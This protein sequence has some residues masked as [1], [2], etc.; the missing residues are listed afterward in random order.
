MW[1]VVV[2]LA[3]LTEVPMYFVSTENTDN[4]QSLTASSEVPT[5]EV[6]NLQD[7]L[8]SFR[9]RTEGTT[10]FVE[11]E[12]DEEHLI[13]FW[14]LWYNNAQGQDYARLRLAATQGELVTNPVVDVVDFIRR[15]P[16][17]G[18]PWGGSYS[19][20][21]TTFVDFGDVLDQ[22]A[23]T[24]FAISIRFRTEVTGAD[25][26]LANKLD[27]LNGGWQFRITSGDVLTATIFDG[28]N[29]ETATT[30]ATPYLDGLWHEARMEVDHTLEVMRLYVDNML[31][32]TSADIS[33][34]GDLSSAVVLA[35]G[36]GVG[37]IADLFDGQLDEFR[38]WDGTLP[39]TIQST[40]GLIG[41]FSAPLPA[42]LGLYWKANTGSGTVAIDETTN[43]FD[44]T[45][46]NGF[47]IPALTL[48]DFGAAIGFAGTGDVDFGDILDQG[49]A[50][51]FTV[52]LR[53]KTTLSGIDNGL[54]G[55][56]DG[57]GWYG[58][59]NAADNFS[60]FFTDGVDTVP[61]VFSATPYL[62][63]AWHEVR[64]EW[65]RGADGVRLYADN[66]LLVGIVGLGA[67]G[68]LAN[69]SP[70]HV[71]TIDVVN[72]DWTGELD[73]FRFWSTIPT[74]AQS[75]AGF[76]GE[77]TIPLPT[78]LELYWKANE[79][80]G[81]IAYDET[82]N[83]FNGVIT[84]GTWITPYIFTDG[85]ESG[86]TSGWVG[87]YHQIGNIPNPQPAT[88]FRIDVNFATNPDGFVE[89]GALFLAPRLQFPNGQADNWQP[90]NRSSAA[91]KSLMA[92]GDETRGD[93]AN[94]RDVNFTIKGMTKDQHWGVFDPLHRE[95]RDVRPV[96]AVLDD[97]DGSAAL[98]PMN[99]TYYGYFQAV[100]STVRSNNKPARISLR[101]P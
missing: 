71:G 90:T 53:F 62:D 55:K 41:E 99:Y 94:K 48:A 98:Y 39:T 78:G 16:R 35:A 14:G 80:A 49:P 17:R 86:D 1:Y 45:I 60:F 100:R 70:L 24:D 92:G 58:Y 42:A 4:L 64:I 9:W 69:T 3:I 36:A 57:T 84:N 33:A 23:A 81:F 20:D 21:G 15:D 7:P 91:R 59:I 6:T 67:V 82:S 79:G 12:L 96:G 38:F 2:L 19:F 63:G 18:W 83:G 89:A 31:L 93:G 43:G 65:D 74:T 8:G 22:G 87:P 66:S 50:D 32:D 26:G 76:A 47:W 56:Y 72:F 88:W 13:D 46:T 27:G 75:A 101:E 95:R 34:V 5:F 25:N 11:G 85:F 40:A 28:V 68:S 97:D 29:T 10:A 73:E 51:S 52:S 37:T 77:F 44:G 30:D 61:I 54:C